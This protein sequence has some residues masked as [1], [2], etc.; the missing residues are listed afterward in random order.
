MAEIV[1]SVKTASHRDYSLADLRQMTGYSGRTIARYIQMGLVPSPKQAGSRTRYSRAA[2]G[3]LLA[4]AKLRREGNEGTPDVKYE[5]RHLTDEEVEAHAEARD[6]LAS[7]VVA[8]PGAPSQR[9]VAHPDDVHRAALLPAGTAQRWV[10][11]SLVPGLELMVHE[12]GGEIVARLAHEI[13]S[14]YGAG[15]PS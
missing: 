8:S 5:L 3:R 11:V 12:G 1:R 4:I 7:V 14:K 2:L 15:A 9:M 13:V 6:P 10:R